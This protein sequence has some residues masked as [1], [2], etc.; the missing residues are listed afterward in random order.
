MRS[1]PVLQILVSAF[2][3]ATK[4]DE[5]ASGSTM[6]SYTSTGDDPFQGQQSTSNL[7]ASTSGAFAV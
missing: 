5:L 7:T 3:S 1:P 6:V 2:A 4:A